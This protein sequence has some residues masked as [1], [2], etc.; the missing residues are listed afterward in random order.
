MTR[1]VWT[2]PARDD[3]R[4]IRAYIAQDSERYARVVTARLIAAVRRL[5]EFPLSGRV[6]PEL[7]RPTIREL[8]EGAYRIVYR[9]TPDAIQV[10]AVVHG[11]R[12]FPPTEGDSSE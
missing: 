11:A 12:R 2:R 1:V 8:I 4:E 5:R 9:V 6:V 3:L 7:A 10:L